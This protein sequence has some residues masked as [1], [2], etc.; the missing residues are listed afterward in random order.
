MNTDTLNARGVP[1]IAA[2]QGRRLSTEHVPGVYIA[3]GNV[4]SSAVPPCGPPGRSSARQNPLNDPSPRADMNGMASAWKILAKK[5]RDFTWSH[6]MNTNAHLA[7]LFPNV[8]VEVIKRARKTEGYKEA[9]IKERMGF[10]SL[11]K[12][13]F[14][15]AQGLCVLFTFAFLLPDL[16]IW[17]LEVKVGIVIAHLISDVHEWITIPVYYLAKPVKS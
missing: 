12:T 17:G 14:L 3:A 5:E 11:G 2:P 8:P 13:G 4:P 15:C 10:V 1:P 6:R 16:Y 9:L 7:R